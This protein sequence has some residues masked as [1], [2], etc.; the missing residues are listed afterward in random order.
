MR[1]ELGIPK[2]TFVKDELVV[3]TTNTGW[4]S[5]KP[6]IRFYCSDC[7]NEFIPKLLNNKNYGNWKTIEELVSNWD[8]VKIPD[9][10]FDVVGCFICALDERVNMGP[11]KNFFKDPTEHRKKFHAEKVIAE[12]T[13]KQNE[14]LRLIQKLLVSDGAEAE[15]P[16][17]TVNTPQI[18]TKDAPAS[19]SSS[20]SSSSSQQTS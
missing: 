11:N 4:Q 10:L 5:P 20:S 9:A 1:D 16:M 13:R 14:N 7:Q 17:M 19:S 12:L 8:S 3:N 6:F 15:P 18:P 2:E